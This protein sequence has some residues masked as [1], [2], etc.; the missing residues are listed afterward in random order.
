MELVSWLSY[1]IEFDPS[2]R[3]QNIQ[4]MLSSLMIGALSLYKVRF[5][6]PAH[7]GTLGTTHDS[8]PEGD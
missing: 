5:H 7:V 1:D 2:V 4:I 6:G 8:H 3:R